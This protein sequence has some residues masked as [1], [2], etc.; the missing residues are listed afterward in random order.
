MKRQ[1]VLLGS[2]IAAIIAAGI[3]MPSLVGDYWL[4]V[5]TTLSMWIALTESWIVLS[6]MTGYISLGHAVFVGLG[7]YV[8]VLTWGEVPIWL[9]LMLAGLTAGGTALLIG[10]PC[11]RVRGPYFVILTLGVSE[12]G[13]YVVVNIEASLGKFGR[14]VLG[15]PEIDDIFRMMLALAVVAFLL[16]WFVRRS[17]FGAGL[18]ALREDEEASQMVGISATHLKITAFVVS[19]II[20][21]MVGSL[22]VLRSGYFE[23]LQVFNPLVSLTII[24]MATIGGSDDAPGPLLGTIFL[25]GLSELLWS[26]A[27]QLYMVILGALLIFFVLNA[28]DGLYGRIRPYF[29]HLK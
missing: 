9:G 28:P 15:G 21:G 24:T 12:F 7:A 5:L 2:T 1:T 6:G 19:A 3:A 13:K 4:G 10:L 23:P 11:L 25:V 16:A 29:S 18:R 27:P 20:P 22:L 8:F 14:L 26:T 17:R